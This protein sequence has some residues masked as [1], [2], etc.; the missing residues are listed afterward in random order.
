MFP[1]AQ[2]YKGMTAGMN[3]VMALTKSRRWPHHGNPVA[4]WCFG[5]VEVRRT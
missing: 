1:L 4:E 2:T 5:S 3:E